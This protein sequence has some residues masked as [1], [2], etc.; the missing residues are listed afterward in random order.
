MGAIFHRF[1]CSLKH[2][3]KTG[4]TNRR[5]ISREIAHA[6][7]CRLNPV[8]SGVPVRTK[9]RTLLH[10]CRHTCLWTV[11]IAHIHPAFPVCQTVCIC[12]LLSIVRSVP[13]PVFHQASRGSETKSKSQ[14]NK[15]HSRNGKAS[16]QPLSVLFLSYHFISLIKTCN[17]YRYI[18]TM[19]LYVYP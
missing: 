15:R 8:R 16:T 2:V 11:A 12:C 1:D 19:V 14:Y 9:W 5:F 10:W 13:Q 18:R 3:G 6:L 7:I 4:Y 17:H